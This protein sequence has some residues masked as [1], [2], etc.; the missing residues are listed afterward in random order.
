MTKRSV[1]KNEEEKQNIICYIMTQNFPSQC[2]YEERRNIKRKAKDFTVQNGLLYIEDSGVLKR[3]FC[4]HETELI[5]SILRDNH[6][7]GHKGINLLNRKIARTYAGISITSIK[8]FIK[9][10]INCQMET[11]PRPVAPLTPIVP[12]FVRERSIVDTI[13]LSEYA[14]GND[15]NRYLFTFVDSF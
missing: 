3:Y 13:D 2:T 12:S 11:V 15:Q 8:E 7:P 1:I 5:S 4:S 10:C 6:M 14:D 9:Q